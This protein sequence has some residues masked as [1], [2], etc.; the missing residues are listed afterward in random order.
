MCVSTRKMFGKAARSLMRKSHN[1][2]KRFRLVAV[3]GARRRLD[4][5]N[6]MHGNRKR[7]ASASSWASG[8][9]PS[10][11][12]NL[13]VHFVK[14][15]TVAGDHSV[16]SAEM[17]GFISTAGRKGKVVKVQAIPAINALQAKGAPAFISGR[18]R[19][20]QS[21]SAH[22][23]ASRRLCLSG[24]VT[25]DPLAS[26]GQ[27]LRNSS[28]P[29]RHRESSIERKW[30]AERGSKRCPDMSTVRLPRMWALGLR[31]NHSRLQAETPKHFSL[32]LVRGGGACRRGQRNGGDTVREFD[33]KDI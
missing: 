30:R 1:V 23:Q 20:Y 6:T 9:P 5:P 18:G 14:P 16:Q 7:A 13:C 26:A 21:M 29:M 28:R 27:G 4:R 11:M 12:V 31:R 22:F 17:A 19:G 32:G 10:P 8:R 33:S 25:A 15:R 3:R 2:R 24:K